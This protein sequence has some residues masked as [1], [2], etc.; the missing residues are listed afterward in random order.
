MSLGVFDLPPGQY[1][2]ERDHF[3]VFAEA[4]SRWNRGA[5]QW[6]GPPIPDPDVGV[7]LYH[8]DNRTRSQSLVAVFSLISRPPTIL[9]AAES[10]IVNRPT[11]TGDQTARNPHANGIFQGKSDKTEDPKAARSCPPCLADEFHRERQSE[12]RMKHG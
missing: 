4:A 2:A 11:T 12:P 7:R 8:D 10:S 1:P 3:N 9:R 6:F 5:A